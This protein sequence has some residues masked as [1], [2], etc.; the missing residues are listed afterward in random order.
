VVASHSVLT[1]DILLAVDALCGATGRIA[2]S[3]GDR[4]RFRLPAVGPFMAGVGV[5]PGTPDAGRRLLEQG[6]VVGPAPGGMRESLRPTTE[7]FRIDGRRRFGFIRPWL[8]T[9]V[10]LVLTTCPAADLALTLDDDPPT[11]LAV[12]MPLMRGVGPTP[13]PLPTRLSAPLRPGGGRDPADPADV[14]AEH[15]R[16]S[17]AIEAHIRRTVEDLGLAP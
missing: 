4:F 15:R 6:A 3:L 2:R 7:P 14:E 9:R 8:Q 11:R 12:P 13:L 5:V 17:A 10:P 1:C 16:V